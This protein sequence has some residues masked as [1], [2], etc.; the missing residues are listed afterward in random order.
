MCVCVCGVSR[1]GGQK[2]KKV[3]V[4]LSLLSFA[5]GQG[6]RADWLR[7]T[8]GCRCSLLLLHVREMSFPVF[9]GGREGEVWCG[10]ERQQRWAEAAREA[11]NHS[12]LLGV[13]CRGKRGHSQPLSSIEQ[14]A[15]LNKQN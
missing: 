3:Q 5:G 1:E 11:A 15:V 2:D 9:N 4:V 14:C 8:W 10:D 13:P 6:G 7:H 12:V